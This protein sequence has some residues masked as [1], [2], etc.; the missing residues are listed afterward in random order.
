MVTEP[1]LRVATPSD[2]P[3]LARMLVV[4]FNFD[5]TERTP[6]EDLIAKEVPVYVSGWGRAG[7][8]GLIAEVEGRPAGAVWSRLF[9]ASASTYGHVAPDVPEIACLGLEPWAAGMGLG[10]RLFDALVAYLRAAGYSGASLSVEDDNTLA[11]GMYERRGFRAVGRVGESDTMLLE[12]G[13]DRIQAPGTGGHAKGPR[14]G[15]RS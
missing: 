9:P 2:E 6:V 5:G 14:A 13:S 15:D 10:S 1:V 7:D 3:F 11:R 8:H 4:A 12:F